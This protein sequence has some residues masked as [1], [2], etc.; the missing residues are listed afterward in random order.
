MFFD[1][2]DYIQQL[3]VRFLIVPRLN[4]LPKLREYVIP[5]VFF[6]DNGDMIWG[7]MF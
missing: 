5:I 6:Q 2:G 1:L 7:R 4:R 3:T